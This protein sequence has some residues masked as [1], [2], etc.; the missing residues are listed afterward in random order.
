MFETLD[1]GIREGE[2]V[3]VRHIGFEG[4]EADP[5]DDRCLTPPA[6]TTGIVEEMRRG[7][8]TLGQRTR[9]GV[10]VIRGDGEGPETYELDEAELEPVDDPGRVPTAEE[11]TARRRKD[12]EAEGRHPEL[13][14]DVVMV[15]DG[16]VR[17]EYE[18]MRE[19]AT[20]LVPQLEAR[21]NATARTAE[22]VRSPRF[23]KRWL[24][25]RLEHYGGTLQ[26]TQRILAGTE[27][28]LDA[29]AAAERAETEL[30]SELRRSR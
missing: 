11:V 30:A 6:G 14:V 9:G 29:L 17:R 28:A 10:A 20:A 24:E 27:A 21:V 3:R 19:I 22:R 13:C 16:Q 7:W 26:E 1:Y 4:D 12:R 23:V 8:T 18:E 25:R 5:F 15:R 2:R